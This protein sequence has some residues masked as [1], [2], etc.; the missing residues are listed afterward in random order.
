[1]NDF[2]DFGGD[3]NSYYS[4]REC[5]KHTERLLKGGKEL[6]IVSPYIDAYYA[7][8]LINNSSGKRIRIISSSMDLEA[9][10][11]FSGG[12]PIGLFVATV[13]IVFGIDYLIYSIG[14]LSAVLLIASFLTI[15]AVMILFTRIK[16]NISI[17]I[18]KN[19]VHAK[20]Y[21][22]EKGAIHGSANLT[23][24]GMHKNVEHIEITSEKEKVERLRK[25]FLRIWGSV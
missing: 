2:M 8:F 13:L 21:I 7:R 11:I 10:N 9:K 18:P 1:M 25:E 6:L 19:F 15:L 17:K 3:L 22:T 5:Y 24:K 14:L 12:R 23:Y 4:G 16:Y 20:M